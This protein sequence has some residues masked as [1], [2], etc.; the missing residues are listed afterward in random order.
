MKIKG[1]NWFVKKLTNLSFILSLIF[2]FLLLDSS[3]YTI[4]LSNG[5]YVKAPQSP[6]GP[7]VKDD[8]PVVEKVYLKS[9]PG[10]AYN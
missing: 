7:A 1:D 8:K 10:P 3:Y 9:P 4:N 6:N 2:I 5:A